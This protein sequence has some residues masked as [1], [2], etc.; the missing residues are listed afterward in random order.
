MTFIFHPEATQ[1]I[2]R[3]TASENLKLTTN[4]LLV[5]QT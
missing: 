1:I 4:E 2:L 5:N 3:N